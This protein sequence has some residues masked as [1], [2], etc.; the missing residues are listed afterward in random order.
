MST[1]DSANFLDFLQALRADPVGQNLILSAAVGMKPFSGSD[2]SPMTDVSGFAKVFDHIGL[3]PFPKTQRAS[4]SKT[5][6]KAIMAY[7]V[8]GPWST[9]A[10][11][12]AP[13]DDSCASAQQQAGSVE[14]AFKAWTGAGFPADQVWFIVFSL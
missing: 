14:S 3:Y 11:P 4:L 2:G 8:Y 6:Q 1:D 13:L 5:N 10:G 12:N 9:A 7:D